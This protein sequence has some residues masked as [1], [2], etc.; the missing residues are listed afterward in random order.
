MET[1]TFV[2]PTKNEKFKAIEEKIYNNSL[3]TQKHDDIVNRFTNH[4]PDKETIDKMAYVRE[5][6]RNLAF[7]IERLC[8]ES[9][10]K[11]TALTQLSFVMMSANSAIVQK[12]PVNTAEL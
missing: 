3:T 9:R 12:C 8:P 7:V 6:V 5:R 10:E 4:I 1:H 11:D 2:H